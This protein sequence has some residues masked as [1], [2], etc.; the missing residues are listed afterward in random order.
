MDKIKNNI[1]HNLPI[2][3][4]IIAVVVIFCIITFGNKNPSETVL[5]DTSSFN[6]VTSKDVLEFLDEK[7]A[8]MI[9]IGSKKCSATEYFVPIM[10]ISQAKGEYTINYLELLDEDPKSSEFKDLVNELDIV[11]NYEGEEKEL[12]EYMGSTPMIIIIKNKKIVYGTVGTI[13]ENALTQLANTY[14]V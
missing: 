3:L 4:I 10:E 11:I 9:V 2:Y 6:V 14:G 5:F 1:E 12:K 7:E 13:S 8:R